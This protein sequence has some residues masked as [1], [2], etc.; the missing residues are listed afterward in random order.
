M[1]N[2]MLK[3][4]MMVVS[5]LVLLTGAVS[6]RNEIGNFAAKGFIYEGVE[7]SPGNQDP[8]S[9]FHYGS[10]FLLASVAGAE[11]RYLTV[12]VNSREIFK[13]IGVTG[14]AWSVAVFDDGAHVGTVY[15]EIVSGEIQDIISE[16]GALTGRQILIDLRATSG[17]G[18]FDNEWGQN[19]SGTL[20]MTTDL[21]TKQK[22]TTAIE[23]FN[24]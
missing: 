22:R 20:I 24:F 9:G 11:S 4:A 14:G 17:T 23:T 3:M 15:G 10:T 5:A 13:G 16:K 12:S 2:K 21:L 6:A 8:V 1:K 7:S 18:I 19:I